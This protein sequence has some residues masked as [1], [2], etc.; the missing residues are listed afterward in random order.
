MLAGGLWSVADPPALAVGGASAAG[1]TVTLR[2]SSTEPIS[3]QRVILTGQVAGSAERQV[4]LYANPYPYRAATVRVLA[5]TTAGPAGSFSFTVFPDRLVGYAAV[6]ADARAA[7]TVR[8]HPRVRTITKLSALALGRAK[9]VV[10]VFH[11]RDLDWNNVAVS[12]SFAS[13]RHGRWEP[14]LSTRTTRLS[15]YVTVLFT[16]VT[17]PPGPFSWRACFSAPL[18]LA[19]EDPRTPPHCRGLGYWGGGSLP[20]GYPPASAITSAEQFVAARTGRASVAVMD[21]QGRLAGANLDERFPA[22]SVVKSMLL[23]GYLRRLDASG[24]HHVDAGSN[25]FLYPMIHVSDNNA[26]TRC[27]SI[28]GDDGLY[29]VARAAGL[30]DFS[31]GGGWLTARISAGDMAR[32]FFE[33]DSLI[34]REFVGYARGLLSGIDPSQAWGIPAVARPLGYQVFFKGG[35]LPND[36]VINQVARLEGHGRTFTIAVLTSGPPGMSYGIATI[37]GVTRRLLG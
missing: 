8:I 5:T 32:F 16:T 36:G 22:A 21:S 30:R 17:L 27:W 37:E 13:G 33:M 23:V 7:A 2:A 20:E 31:V 24:R 1:P 3:G 18:D 19:L 9:V 14:T 34:P 28:V 11:P 10:L 4:K 25:S 6:L 29:S 26:A 35:W 12:W 15:S